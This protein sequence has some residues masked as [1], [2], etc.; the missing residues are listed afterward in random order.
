MPGARSLACESDKAHECSRTS[1]VKIGGCS[2]IA[3]FTGRLPLH[4]EG[5]SIQRVL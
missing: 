1:S 2:A 3:A 5:I 4:R